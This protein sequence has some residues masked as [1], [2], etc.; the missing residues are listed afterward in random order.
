M[1]LVQRIA[2]TEAKWGGS[3]YRKNYFTFLLLRIVSMCWCPPCLYHGLIGCDQG[4]GS[5]GKRGELWAQY[6]E[7][8]A[9]DMRHRTRVDEI[10]TR[11]PKAVTPTKG[12]LGILHFKETVAYDFLS[13]MISPKVPN[14]SSDS[15][16]KAV[17]NIDSIS[18][19]ISTFKV[20]P[21]Y[22]PLQRILVSPM[23][24]TAADLAMRYGPLQQI[25]LYAMGHCGGFGY[26]L[27]AT[28]RNEAVQ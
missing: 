2:Q 12:F 7:R 4:G 16:S 18:T 6:C 23:S 27:W 11:A 3:C 13:K 25:W 9:V 22:G 26:A 1:I 24:A 21:R 17:S 8:W 20:F 28:A 10:H 5:R 19:R 14:R 15:W